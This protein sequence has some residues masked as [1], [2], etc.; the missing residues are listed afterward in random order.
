MIKMPKTKDLT[1]EKIDAWCDYLMKVAYHTPETEGGKE[2]EALRQ[3]ATRAILDKQ[4]Q[5]TEE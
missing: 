1:K 2:I 4:I 3:M 5:R